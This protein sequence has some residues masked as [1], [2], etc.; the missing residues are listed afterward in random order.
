MN[1]GSFYEFIVESGRVW[2]ENGDQGFSRVSIPFA[3][4]EKNQIAYSMECYHSYLKM[5]ALLQH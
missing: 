1:E 5:M 2:N 4:K 3:L